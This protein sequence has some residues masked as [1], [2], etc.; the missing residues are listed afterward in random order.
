MKFRFELLIPVF[1]FV[2]DFTSFSELELSDDE[3]DERFFMRLVSLSD[4][5][6]ELV[7][8]DLLHE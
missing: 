1:A 4:E 5:D 7:L 2:D 6:D 8:S 3:L